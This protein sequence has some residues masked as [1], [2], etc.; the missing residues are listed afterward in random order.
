MLVDNLFPKIYCRPVGNDIS[1]MVLE[2]A[3]AQLYGNYD[4]I[5]L[6]HSTD[7]SRDLT[8]APTIY[9]DFKDKHQLINQIKSAFAN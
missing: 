9:V 6:G 5:V 7:A 1:P 8:G 3:Y 4:V 2:K